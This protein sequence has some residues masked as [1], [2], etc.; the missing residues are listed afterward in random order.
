MRAEER[1]GGKAASLKGSLL[2]AYDRGTWQRSAEG[3]TTLACRR[4]SSCLRVTPKMLAAR[5]PPSS[6]ALPFSVIFRQCEKEILVKTHAK[7]LPPPRRLLR[8]ESQR[9]GRRR[10]LRA[11]CHLSGARQLCAAAASAA[12]SAPPPA[13]RLSRPTARAQERSRGGRELRLAPCSVGSP[14]R[15]NRRLYCYAYARRPIP[16]I[17]AILTGL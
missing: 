9:G 17:A 8:R 1:G 3:E 5:P 10:R 15:R 14:D 16:L 7:Q 11:V 12:A 13:S 6:T 2:C 4:S